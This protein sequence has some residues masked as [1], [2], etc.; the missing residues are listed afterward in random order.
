MSRRMSKEY[1]RNS[2]AARPALSLVQPLSQEQPLPA[3]RKRALKILFAVAEAYPLVKTGGLGDVA[4]ALPAALMRA[5]MDVRVML[6]AYPHVLNMLKEVRPGPDLGVVL[7][8]HSA[9]LL[10]SVMPDTGVKLL[11]VDCPALYARGGNIYQN[12]TGEDWPDNHLRFGLLAR[13]AAMIAVAGQMSGWRPDVLHANDW[14]TGLAPYY[15]RAWGGGIPKSVFTIHNMVYQGLFEGDVLADLAI[16]GDVPPPGIEFWGRASFLKAGLVYADRVTTV[17]PTYAREVRAPAF[18]EGLDGVVR[19]RRDMVAGIVNGIDETVWNPA[20]DPAIAA[21]YDAGHLAAK[22]ANKAALKELGLAVSPERPVLGIVSRLVRQKGIDLVLD[23]LP[24]ILKEGAQL[25]VLGS[26]ESALEDRLRAA[27]AMHPGDVAAV[28]GYDEKL[29]HRVIAGADMILMPSRFEPCG[30][31]QLYGQRY[32]SLPIAHRVG[33]LADT[34]HDLEDGFAF[35]ALSAPEIAKAI[36]RAVARYRNPPA[37]R[38]LQTAAM[39]KH[40]GWDACAALYLDL[41]EDLT[42]TDDRHGTDSGA[43]T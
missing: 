7:G 31:T 29:A 28:I 33:G 6:P 30:L 3:S 41:Y 34:V 9:R 40:T 19:A 27:A 15:M 5:G 22:A 21:R 38:A 1:G 16:P 43:V 14:H 35:T 8:G 39:A 25:I 20:T 2:L 17:S 11:L 36:R 12:F 13:A 42:G 37:W 26:G 18:G 4:A 24:A 32:G 23:A 10:E